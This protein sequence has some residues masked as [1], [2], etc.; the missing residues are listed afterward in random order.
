MKARHAGIP[1]RKAAGIGNV[2]RHE[3]QDVAPDV[4]WHGVQD[5]LLPLET[6]CR[7]ELV[8]ERGQ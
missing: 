7:I 1:W 4:L 6:A 5:N 3:Y 2:L 8:R